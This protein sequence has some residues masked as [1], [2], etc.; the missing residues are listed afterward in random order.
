MELKVATLQ[1][2]NSI[3]FPEKFISIIILDMLAA[4]WDVRDAVPYGDTEN[5]DFP[6]QTLMYVQGYIMV[7][8]KN[9][10]F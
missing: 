1:I 8:L 5:V 10:L 3:C 9:S 4:F 7:F 6:T 2:C